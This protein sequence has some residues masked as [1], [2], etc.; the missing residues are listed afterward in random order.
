MHRTEQKLISNLHFR[1]CTL[2]C[3]SCFFNKKCFSSDKKFDFN[4]FL[5][6]KNGLENALFAAIVARFWQRIGVV[7]LIT[8]VSFHFPGASV[9]DCLVFQEKY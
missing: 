5:T 1:S 7:S 9:L 3:F 2:C 4:I 6:A 8:F